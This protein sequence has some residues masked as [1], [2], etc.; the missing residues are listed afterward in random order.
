MSK[1]KL[2]ETSVN[3]I[4]DST[5]NFLVFAEEI[6]EQDR[7]IKVSDALATLKT[8]KTRE[9]FFRKNCNYIP[10]QEVILEQSF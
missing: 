4:I 2:P 10:P 9:G 5:I 6:S 3:D 7:T 8:G 1:H